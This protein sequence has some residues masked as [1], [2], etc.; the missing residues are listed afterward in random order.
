MGQVFRAVDQRLGRE[1][2]IKMLPADMA[3]DADFQAR[4]LREARAASALNHPGIVTLHD[5]ETVDGRSFLVMELVE[6]ERFSDLATKAIPWQRAVEI[7]AGVADALAAA[8]AR[9]ILHRDIKSDNLML[10]PSGQAKVLDFGLAKLRDVRPEADSE[11]GSTARLQRKADGSIAPQP[12][13][14]PGSGPLAAG[15]PAESFT[16]LPYAMTARPAS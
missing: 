11:A 12:N 4:L 9:G 14:A 1:V 2:A 8:H 6:G 16:K 15:T 10:T 3:G 13:A 7:V 5:I